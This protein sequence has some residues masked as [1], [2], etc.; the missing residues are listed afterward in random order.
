MEIGENILGKIKEIATT[1]GMDQGG[2]K[3]EV[4]EK[5]EHG[6]DD[7]AA[8]VMWMSEHQ[9]A[10]DGEIADVTMRILDVGRERESKWGDGSTHKA[11][12]V[13]TIIVR[14]GSPQIYTMSFFDDDIMQVNGMVNGNIYEM[15]GRIS[16]TTNKIRLLDDSEI[17]PSSATMPPLPELLEELATDNVD[18]EN[19]PREMKVFKAITGRQLS[20]DYNPGIIVGNINSTSPKTVW[21]NDDISQPSEGDKIYIY[22]YVGDGG[23]LFPKQIVARK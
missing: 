13:S 3:S 22:G 12:D 7:E 9:I 19:Y 14:D 8:L 21:L 20:S 2:I 16:K 15:R 6:F 1:T 23:K 17:K 11:R 5:M 4:S 10:L 18:F